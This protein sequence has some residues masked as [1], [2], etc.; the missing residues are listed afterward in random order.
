MLLGDLRAASL[1]VCQF[2]LPLHEPSNPEESV[3]L[4]RPMSESV[5][6]QSR[7]LIG[8]ASLV[9]LAFIAMVEVGPRQVST[10]STGAQVRP[11]LAYS[12]IPLAFLTSG[13]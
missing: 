1:F 3:R 12:R 9:S 13:S 10:T 2:L 11:S 5:W 6:A 8:L 4:N 7:I